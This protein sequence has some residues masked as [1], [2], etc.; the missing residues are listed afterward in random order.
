V[1]SQGGLL[2]GEEGLEVVFC[3]C[4]FGEPVGVVLGFVVSLTA[5]VVGVSVGVIVVVASVGVGLLVG[6]GE[7]V[8]VS[9][10]VGDG[11]LVE[12]DEV[13]GVGVFVFVIA[14]VGVSVGVVSAN[15]TTGSIIRVAKIR[16]M[17][18][19]VSFCIIFFIF[20]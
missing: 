5:L 8:G 16:S 3:A 19:V 12:V 7:V 11:S 1:L 2:V 18:Y 4:V 15:T 9:D 14:G 13:V 17:I 20:L 10:G 6:D